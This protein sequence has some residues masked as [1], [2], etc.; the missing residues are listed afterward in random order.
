MYAIKLKS[1]T[2]NQRCIKDHHGHSSKDWPAIPYREKETPIP[3]ECNI[4]CC[5]EQSAD[6]VCHAIAYKQQTSTSK[7]VC[8]MYDLHM[9]NYNSIAKEVGLQ[10]KDEG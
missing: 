4:F 6:F 2:E 1:D 9:D 8:R 7:G 3:E 5:S 10:K